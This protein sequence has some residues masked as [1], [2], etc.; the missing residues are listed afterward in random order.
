[1]LPWRVEPTARL[2]GDPS[3]NQ[4]SDQDAGSDQNQ[5]PGAGLGDEP[6]VVDFA[7]ENSAWGWEG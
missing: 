2:R 7:G 1:M 5:Q 4:K 6:E 3:K